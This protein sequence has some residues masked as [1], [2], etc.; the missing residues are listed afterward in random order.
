MM[1]LLSFVTACATVLSAQTADRVMGVVTQ[2]SPEKRQVALRADD[3][4]IYGAFAEDNATVLRVEPG[5][6]DMSKAEKTDF[7]AIAV[8]DR[9]LVR[10]S[11]ATETRT[12]A[13]RTLLVISK[14]S[15]AARDS[16]ALQAWRT[17]SLG[18]VVKKIDASARTVALTARLPGS[19]AVREWVVTV[20]PQ[21]SIL[22]YA[23]ESVKFADARPATFELIREG[24]QMRV[25]GPRN[26]EQSSAVA[27]AIVFGSFRTVAGEIKTV[28]AAAHEVTITDLQTKKRLVIRAGADA[29]IRKMMAPPGGRAGF[30]G[31]RQ[32]GPGPGQGMMPDFQRLIERL[33]PAALTDL[34]PGEAIIASVAKGKDPASA[35]AITL[36]AGVDFLLRASP[37]ALSQ[38]V[39]GWNLEANMPQ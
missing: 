26:E 10:G 23:D 24:D 36:V 17:Q 38:M 3:G 4:Q 33:P 34:Q 6:R 21:T 13:A 20:A 31:P 11:I 28:D 25:R 16:K 27:E 19:P 1:R 30:G 9:L 5:E 14:S 18:G 35:K 7:A 8:G 12:V 39:A 29:N 37:A 15:L 2:I 32:G 22:R